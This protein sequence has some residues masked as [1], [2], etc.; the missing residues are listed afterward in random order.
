MVKLRLGAYIPR[1]VC[2]SVPP[3]SKKN[4]NKT[5]TEARVAPFSCRGEHKQLTMCS[6]VVLM[7]EEDIRWWMRRICGSGFTQY[8]KM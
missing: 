7:K 3:K 5:S 4:V 2:L 8:D 1:Y 6:S